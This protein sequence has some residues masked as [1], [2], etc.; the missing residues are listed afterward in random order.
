MS[1]W[2]RETALALIGTIAVADPRFAGV[3]PEEARNQAD[4]WASRMD[5][6]G[7]PMEYAMQCVARFYDTD[8]KGRRI[9]VADILVP[10]GRH[11]D[12]EA[13]K[14]R[15]AEDRL[16]SQISD[17][18]VDSMRWNVTE[19]LPTNQPPWFR[20]FVRQNTSE[21]NK[22][23]GCG[24]GP[25][26][27]KA[28]RDMTERTELQ[29]AELSASTYREPEFHELRRDERQRDCGTTGCPC[30]H[31]ECRSGFLDAET[32]TGAVRRC[33]WCAEAVEMTRELAPKRKG[34][35]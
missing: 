33:T 8:Q 21:W 5:H 20:D 34:R 26:W 6:H 30:P 17:A 23:R 29:V 3:T 35:R 15:S 7:V 11:Q 32:Q 13:A 12:A 16:M 18:E 9:A 14:A 28:R 19:G 24:P 1:D 2:T 31:T 22:A 4:W 25:A 27:Y 10:W